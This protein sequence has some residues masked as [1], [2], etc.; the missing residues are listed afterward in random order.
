MDPELIRWLR[1]ELEF[2]LRVKAITRPGPTA[3][4]LFER[5]AHIHK[6]L[7]FHHKLEQP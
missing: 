2:L 3:D 1:E 5:S 6:I 7:E 4:L